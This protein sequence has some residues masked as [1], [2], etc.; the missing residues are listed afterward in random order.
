MLIQKQVE[1]HP[2][3]LLKTD[4]YQAMGYREN[5]PDDTVCVLVD[6]VLTDISSFCAPLY[7]YQIQEARQI[8]NQRIQIGNLEFAV[9]GIIGSYLSGVSHVC[10]FV[11]T[12]G[13]GYEA[14]L[15]QVKEQSDIIKEYVIDSIG[16]VIAETCVTLIEQ[17]L[18]MECDLHRT[19]PYSPGYCGWNICEQQKLFSFF[20]CNLVALFYLIHI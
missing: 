6:E 19:P 15:K 8:S 12:A 9:G 20:L 17:E 10:L 4:I 13:K 16:S 3:D 1:L 18:D 2:H 11:A 14:Y 5:V 7:M